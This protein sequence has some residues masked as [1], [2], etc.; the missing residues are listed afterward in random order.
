MPTVADLMGY[1]GAFFLLGTVLVKGMLA[2]RLMVTGAAIGY[3]GYGFAAGLEPVYV[4]LLAL[5][6][7]HVFRLVQDWRLHLLAQRSADSAISIDL[8][9]PFMLEVRRAKG[10]TLFR[11]GEPAEIL[12]YIADGRVRVL[13]LDKS[14]NAG[15]LV[16]EIAIFADN[17]ERIAT[18]VCETDCR[19]YAITGRKVVELAQQNPTFGFAVLRLIIARLLETLANTGNA[20]RS[21]AGHPEW[22]QDQGADRPPVG[23][24]IEVVS[25]SPR[26]IER[27][28][29]ASSSS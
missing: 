14:L 13:E 3:L 8:L 10:T 2:L 1:C 25:R 15:E 17:R 16:G 11:K 9:I 6:P 26:E 19:L 23:A 24:A 22:P 27:V 18:A 5:F 29:P 28:P 7:Y 20:Q 4:P 12:Y 21:P